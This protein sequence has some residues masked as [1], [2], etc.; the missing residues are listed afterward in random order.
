MWWQSCPWAQASEPE[1]GKKCSHQCAEAL[2]MKGQWHKSDTQN[3]SSYLREHVFLSGFRIYPTWH[4]QMYESSLFTQMCW[5]SCPRAHGSAPEKRL[6]HL[7]TSFKAGLDYWS[8]WQLMQLSVSQVSGW[9]RYPGHRCPILK[10]ETH[11]NYSNYLCQGTLVE[12]LMATN[13][14]TMYLSQG[15][16]NHTPRSAPVSPLGA[17][18]G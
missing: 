11:L 10:R 3:T 16:V 15:H 6:L 18:F 12:S 8:L 13:V 1:P 17:H 14:C 5:Q 2:Q 9:H 7:M 4:L